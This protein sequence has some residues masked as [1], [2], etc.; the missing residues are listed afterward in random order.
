MSPIL[1]YAPTVVY[2]PV[3]TTAPA[4]AAVTVTSQP[5]GV[6]VPAVT[7]GPPPIL[8]LLIAV[9]VSPVGTFES[10]GTKLTPTPNCWPALA[11]GARIER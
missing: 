11:P 9:K 2:L 5:Y 6:I 7:V 10:T 4:A 8:A 1:P 3:H